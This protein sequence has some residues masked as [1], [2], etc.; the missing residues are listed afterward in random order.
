MKPRLL[1]SA[2]LLLGVSLLSFVM[3]DLAP[4]DFTDELRLDPLVS[5]ETLEAMRER[6]GLDRPFPQRYLSWLNSQRRPELGPQQLAAFRE[7]QPVGVEVE[8]PGPLGFLPLPV[9]YHI[10][11]GKPIQLQGDGNDEDEVIQGQV[12]IVKDEIRRL[13]QRGLHERTDWFR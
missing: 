2:L 7:A 12:E 4:G 13:I 6:F 9:K 5:S 11:F 10:H 1:T 3:M 8:W